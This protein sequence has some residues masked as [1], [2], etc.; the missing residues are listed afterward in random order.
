[1]AVVDKLPSG[2]WRVRVRRKGFPAQTK[3]FVRRADAEGWGRK[4]ESEQERGLW[5]DTSE[6]EAV[7]LRAALRRYEKE[8]TPKHRGSKKESSHIAVLCDESLANRT[9]ASIQRENVKALRDRWARSLAIATVNR[10]LT[11]LHA[12]FAIAIRDWGMHGIENPVDGMKLKGAT[13]RARRVSND[14]IAAICEAAV[15]PTATAAWL[16]AFVRLAVETAMRRGEL[17]K[18]TWA[19]VDLDKSTVHLPGR[20]DGHDGITKNNKDRDVPLSP[21]AIA[22][23][24]ALPRSGIQVFT[25]S[26]PTVTQ[27]F[28]RA[29]VRA[30]SAYVAKCKEKGRESESGFL[31]DLHFHDLRHEATSRL[32]NVFELHELMKIV[33]HSSPAMLMRYYHPSAADF[34]R[35]LA[36]AS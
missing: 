30:R 8:V 17:C 26:G 28:K 11:I 23:L 34:A 25:Q 9:L 16:P 13:E 4:T 29:V 36:A 12:V 18:M 21:K 31:A 35:R 6:A 20:R 19:M 14:E 3:A 2:K 1:M 15:D 10:R 7:T 5:R 32:A 33:G 24:R 22:C 27:S